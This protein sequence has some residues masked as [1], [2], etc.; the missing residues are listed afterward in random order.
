MDFEK[1]ERKH[2]RKLRKREKEIDN[3]ERAYEAA[4]LNDLPV[5]MQQLYKKN[6]FKRRKING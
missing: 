5:N 6:Y 4:M 3:E 2:I 1:L